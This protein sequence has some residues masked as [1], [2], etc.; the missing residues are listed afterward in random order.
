[1]RNFWHLGTL[2]LTSERQSAQMSKITNDGLTRSG[3]GCCIHMATVS[4]KGLTPSLQARHAILRPIFQIKLIDLLPPWFS[5]PWIPDGKPVEQ[6]PCSFIQ[7]YANN[8]LFMT[9]TPY[10]AN[11]YCVW[12]VQYLLT[13]VL[14]E[15]VEHGACIGQPHCQHITVILVFLQIATYSHHQ[16][17]PRFFTTEINDNNNNNNNLVVFSSSV[18][19]LSSNTG[20]K[21]AEVSG[22]VREAS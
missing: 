1:M 15:K 20:K 5:P 10:M 12:Y 22:K 16:F 6:P 3:T 14:L 11:I 2:T 13:T 19:Q 21:I 17:L 9:W 4:V 8:Q 7:L 18:H